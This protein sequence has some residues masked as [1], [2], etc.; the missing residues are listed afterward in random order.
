[1]KSCQA[2]YLL[3]KIFVVWKMVTLEAEVG[4]DYDIAA[5]HIYAERFMVG[6]RDWSRLIMFGKFEKIDLLKSKWRNLCHTA[7][8][9]FPRSSLK[10]E[11][12]GI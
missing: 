7:I 1:M 5:T 4:T 9:L 10:T 3:Y 2:K 8:L 6:V 12:A 11:S